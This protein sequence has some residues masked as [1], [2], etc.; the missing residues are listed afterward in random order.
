MKISLVSS[1]DNTWGKK[2]ECHIKL[3]GINKWKG[4]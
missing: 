3:K 2:V 1:S 4:K